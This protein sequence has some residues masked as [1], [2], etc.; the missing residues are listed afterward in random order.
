[1]AGFSA[2]YQH[3]I[4]RVL[5]YSTISQIGYMFL[6]LGVG[7]WSA[8]VF[9]F[10]IHAFFKALLFLGAGAVIMAL[11]HEHNMFKM[12]GLRKKLPV[13][14]WTFLIAS[15][16]LAALPLI[17]AGYFSK[18]KILWLAYAGEN[19][20]VILWLA[21]LIGAFITALYTFRMVF[22]TFFGETKM[23]PEQKPGNAILVPLVILAF[24]SFAAGYLELPENMGHFT[25]F[26][27]LVERTLPATSIQHEG[28]STELIFQLIA[29]ATALSG[30][31]V[32]YRL[33]YKKSFSAAEPKRNTMEQFFYKG[34]NFDFLYNKLFV[35]P[36]VWLSK[37]NKNDVID[38]FYK[39]L[40][41]GTQSLNRMLSATQNG[42]VRWYAMV[43]AIGAILM[44]TILLYP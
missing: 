37:I 10:M 40:A 34:W 4:K 12:G 3:D 20:S 24:F 28:H 19:G 21:G 6:A 22:I 8:A 13:V 9:H 16:S 44:L 18:D 7:A 36:Y 39:G 42:N 32:A 5:A 23:E 33:Y 41:A 11:H 27:N 29:A 2:L 31:F 15:G 35:Q 25:L 14:F 30:L 26:S 43:I 1:M 17:T 38:M